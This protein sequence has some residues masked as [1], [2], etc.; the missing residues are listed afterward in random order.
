M[1]RLLASAHP[2]LLLASRTWDSACDLAAQLPAA[3]AGSVD[4]VA[5]NSDIVFLVAP[6]AATCF[7]IAPRIR[8]LV[9]GKPIVDVSNPCLAPGAAVFHASSAAERIAGILPESHVVKALNCMSCHWLAQLGLPNL[10]PAVAAT[11]P[12]AGDCAWAKR[13]V[14]QTLEVAGFD[15]ADAGP[16]S[17]SRWIEGLARILM[18]L[19]LADGA[20]T[21]SAGFQLVRLAPATLAGPGHLARPAVNGPVVNDPVVNDT[22][23]ASGM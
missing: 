9:A 13:T 7:D 4:W 12:V 17:S 5:A 22:A 20:D 14:S 1:A 10:G 15:V 6:I 8:D 23:N 11:V 2:R 16:L 21:A 18:H 3:E 19:E